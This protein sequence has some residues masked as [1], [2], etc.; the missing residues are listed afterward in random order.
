MIDLSILDT[1][2]FDLGGVVVNLDINRTINAFKKLG[3]NNVEQWINPGLHTDIFLKFEVGEISEDEFFYG[4]R[5]LA[6]VTVTDSEIRK[7]WCAMLIDLPP[8][9]VKIIE[10]LKETHNVLLLSNTNTIHVNYF[11]GFAKG[12]SS[13]S[14]LF[15][16]VYYSFLMHDHKP[17]AS[18][19]RSVI[20]REKLIP[21]KTLFIDDAEANIIA[22]Q[23][24]G[25]HAQLITSI[26][27]M[28]NVFKSIMYKN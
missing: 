5:E 15:H 19:F 16:N 23:S 6:G 10:W 12:Y 17:N 3:I 2:I 9:R 24:V 22:A 4:I 28:E 7:A 27:Q 1:I 8:E 11:D 13:M 20:E 21:G 18:I 25:I 14:E 26:N